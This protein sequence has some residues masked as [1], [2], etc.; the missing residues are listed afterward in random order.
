MKRKDFIKRSIIGLG[1]IVGI[2]TA[3]ATCNEKEKE[4]INGDCM[5]S[6]AETAGPFPNKT[7]A[8][9][10]RANI[11]GDRSGVA[12]LINLT[13]QDQS[14][15]CVPL[16]GALV[17]IWHCDAVGNYSE[18]ND[19]TDKH[20]LRGRQQ[21]DANGQVSFISIY[22]GWYPGRAPHIHLEILD[23]KEKSLRV[24]QIAFPEEV[25][26]GVYTSSDYKGAADTSNA[27]DGVFRDSLNNNMADSITGNTTDGYNLTK[28]IVV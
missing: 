4:M 24:S 7:P 26:A 12:L 3:L 16:E 13:I 19:L 27:G 28:T 17:D 8:D 23:A 1:T 18:Y 5:L 20:F 25:S 14:N 22:P 6:P 2:P 15:D 11:I 9:F 10:V 21:T